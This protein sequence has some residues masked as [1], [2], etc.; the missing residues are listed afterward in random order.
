M[1]VKQH[2]FNFETRRDGWNPQTSNS[3][4]NYMPNMNEWQKL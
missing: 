3:Y 4:S 2:M 1:E